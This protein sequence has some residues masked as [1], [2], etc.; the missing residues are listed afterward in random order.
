M[1]AHLKPQSQ[2]AGSGK[3]MENLKP[4]GVARNGL[5][6]GKNVKRPSLSIP[7]P[8]CVLLDRKAE[9][10]GLE[11]LCWRQSGKRVTTTM[12]YIFTEHYLGAFHCSK[13]FTCRINSLNP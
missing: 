13:L 11:C 9:S 3:K 5:N 7:L 10:G 1:Y 6:S 12:I 2:L 8:S 4:F